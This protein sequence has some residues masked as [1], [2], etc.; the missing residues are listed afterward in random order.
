HGRS[1]SDVKTRTRRLH[2]VAPRE[3]QLALVHGSWHASTRHAKLL[4]VCLRAVSMDALTEGDTRKIPARRVHQLPAKGLLAASVTCSRG[5]SWSCPSSAHVGPPG[6]LHLLPTRGLLAAS[7]S[8]TRGPLGCVMV[9]G[10]EG[11]LIEDAPL[12]AK[13]TLAA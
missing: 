11:R 2:D 3:G 1:G 9:V 10:R 7:I 13:G 4:V 8:Y 12:A 6:C 5:P